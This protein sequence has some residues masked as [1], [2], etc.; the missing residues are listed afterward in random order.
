MSQP[1]HPAKAGK[2]E[3]DAARKRVEVSRT[4]RQTVTF[5][6]AYFEWQSNHDD[7]TCVMQGHSD[8]VQFTAP[9]LVSAVE[10]FFR[11]WDCRHDNVPEHYAELACV[12][13][14]MGAVGPVDT[15][16]S[17]VNIGM[18]A[19]PFFEWKGMDRKLAIES[20]KSQ[21]ARMDKRRVERE[22]K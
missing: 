22:G 21:Q 10:S 16:G 6:E 18:A 12:K 20:F 8:H 4:A 11:W 5:F 9:D 17:L 19:M 3:R 1:E 2:V 7:R 15:D 13:I 14:S